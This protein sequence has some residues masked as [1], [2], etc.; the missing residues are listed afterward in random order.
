[1][2]HRCLQTSWERSW[3]FIYYYYFRKKREE[4]ANRQRS[5]TSLTSPSG[6][7]GVRILHFQVLIHWILEVGGF[8]YHEK[9]HILFTWYKKNETFIDCAH[10]CCFLHNVPTENDDARII[11]CSL[12]RVVSQPLCQKGLGEHRGWRCLC[13]LSLKTNPSFLWLTSHSCV[14]W[15]Q[16][17]EPASVPRSS[18]LERLCRFTST[19]QRCREDYCGIHFH[20]VFSLLFCLCVSCWKL[21]INKS[22]WPMPETFDRTNIVYFFIICLFFK[23]SLVFLLYQLTED[24]SLRLFVKAN[25]LRC[26]E[27]K[28]ARN[29]FNVSVQHAEWFLVWTWVNRPWSIVPHSLHASCIVAVWCCVWEWC[30]SRLLCPI[31]RQ[32]VQFC[33]SAACF[34]SCLCIWKREACV[35]GGCICVWMH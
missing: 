35:K 29:K 17:D 31:S 16:V 14:R 26:T 28:E 18:C 3:S 25:V 4:N 27:K 5:K 19:S 11:S 12:C 7:G 8:S 30:V 9:N 1:M 2:K 10:A 6:E 13:G 32:P 15:S 24:A 22:L 23:L 21:S 33:E 20:F 34:R